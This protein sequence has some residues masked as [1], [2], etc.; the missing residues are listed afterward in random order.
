MLK[1]KSSI[2]ALSAVSLLMAT[3][4][5]FTNQIKSV[6]KQLSASKSNPHKDTLSSD[7]NK[8]SLVK[9]THHMAA[10]ATLKN[11]KGDSIVSNAFNF[12][13]MYKG[14]VD[15]RTG[16]Y[17]FSAQLG[18]VS[19][20]DNFGP[21]YN[22]ALHYSSSDPKNHGYGFGWSDSLSH[23]DNTTQ[24]L[25]LSTGGSYKLQWSGNV[26][27]I[28]YY[29]LD[30]LHLK[31][32]PS[33]KYLF[34]A[35]HKDGTKEY[36]NDFGCVVRLENTRGDSLY[37]H[38][39]QQ[40]SLEN[41]TDDSG[42]IVL[43]TDYVGSSMQVHSLKADGSFNTVS[44]D[45]AN[46]HLQNI[47]L[48]DAK[49]RIAFKYISALGFPGLISSVNY[50]SGAQ[51]TLQYTAIKALTG[52]PEVNIPVVKSDS[53]D[54]GFSQP[55]IR[56]DY[57]YGLTNGHNYLGYASGVQ[58]R[59]DVDNLY[60]R[61]DNYTYQTRVSHYGGPS[62]VETYNK[63]HL[64]LNQKLYQVNSGSLLSEIDYTYPQWLDSTITSLPRNYSLATKVSSIAYDTD[65]NSAE[66]KG[67]YP[68]SIQHSTS[69]QYDD[70][71]NLL[72]K[73]TEDG[74]VT[75]NQYAAADANGF[76]NDLTTQTITPAKLPNAPTLSPV[77]IQMSYKTFPSHDKNMEVGATL[78]TGSVESYQKSAGIW[79]QDMSLAG[80]F[81]EDQSSADYALLTSDKL[82]TFEA[83]SKSEKNANL[84]YTHGKTLTLWGKQY[85]V[86]IK[87]VKLSSPSSSE[88]PSTYTYVSSC[89]GKTLMNIDDRGNKTAYAYDSLGR[90]SKVVLHYGS[91]NQL[92]KSYTYQSSSDENSLTIT[93]PNGY[94]KQEIYDGIGRIIATKQEKIDNNGKG[95]LGQWDLL[96][97][98]TY[99]NQ[100][101]VASETSYDTNELGQRQ[102]QTITNNY[103]DVGRLISKSM[104]NGQSVVMGV[105]VVMRRTYSYDLFPSKDTIATSSLCTLN[106]VA[107]TCKTQHLK[108]SEKD[109]RGDKVTSYMFSLDP[110]ITNN[111][112]QPLY[113]GKLKSE[114][115][116]HLNN[117]IAHGKAFDK[118]WLKTWL[119][120]AIDEKA[121]YT[122]NHSSY[123]AWHKVI[124]TTDTDG[125]TTHYAYDQKGRLISKTLA[126]GSI[127]TYHYDG[128]GDL[129]SVGNATSGK[130]VTLGTREYNAFG[131]MIKSTDVLGN[132]WKYTYDIAGDLTD[133]TTPNGWHIHYKYD[134]LGN[135][136]TRSVINHPE[137]DV[138]F[139]YY[140][141]LNKLRTRQDSTGTTSYTY[142]DNGLVL[143]ME[144][145]TTGAAQGE[146]TPSFNET[147]S[148]TLSGKP[149]QFINASGG[150]TLY[151]Y[152][153]EGQLISADYN[154]KNIANYGYNMEGQLI[155][156][157][158][159]PVVTTNSYNTLGQ[160]SAYNTTVSSGE[161]QEKNISYAFTYAQDGDLIKRVRTS[162]QGNTTENYQYDSINNLLNYACSGALCPK[163]NLGNRIN[164]QKYTFDI[165]N[166]IKTVSTSVTSKAKGIQSNI[167]TYQFDANDPI[168]LLRYTNSNPAY[169]QSATIEY[170]KDGNIITNEHNQKITYTPF[171]QMDSVD[172]QSGIVHYQY[173]G[174]NVQVSELAPGQEPIYFEYGM[175]GLSAIQQNNKVTTLLYAGGRIGEI[176]PD[177][178]Q[179]YTVTDQ[180]GSVLNEAVLSNDGK[181]T[182]TPDHTYTPYGIEGD[183]SSKN[184]NAKTPLVQQNLW[185]FDGQLKDPASGYQF[186]G[187]GYH[188]AYNPVMRRFMS[189]DSA[190]PFGKGGFNG[191]IF[192]RNNPVMYGDP[193]G[194]MPKWLSTVLDIVGEIGS[195][196]TIVVGAATANPGVIAL[197]IAGVTSASLSVASGIEGNQG[198]KGVAEG[199]GIASAVI[200]LPTLVLAGSA[201]SVSAI[202]TV[203]SDVSTMSKVAAVASSSLLMT[204]AATGTAAFG[205]SIFKSG[206][207]AINILTY[208]SLGSGVVGGGLDSISKKTSAG[209][210]SVKVLKGYKAAVP[211]ESDPIF[212]NWVWV[213][214]GKL[215]R[216]SAPYYNENE[217][218]KSQ[219][220]DDDAVEYLKK[221]GV[222]SV[223][224]L[225]HHEL[226]DAE[227]KLL[228]QND[229]EYVFLQVEDMHS[230]SKEQLEKGAAAIANSKGAALVYCGYGQGRTGTQI[231][232][233]QILTGKTGK[234]QAV[235][236][237]TIETKEQEDILFGSIANPRKFH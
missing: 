82:T 23:Y 168:H 235:V 89:N 7:A 178:N 77:K 63:Y 183:T 57:T 130:D 35:I 182:V 42:K 98:K 160:L 163:D 25:S 37:F 188:R 207:P 162:N 175:G 201:S 224:S 54:P 152:D 167:T 93:Y 155:S 104:S 166:N 187:N 47:L 148:Y 198:H 142:A 97:T 76:I 149:A 139:T 100:G 173:N 119:R 192:A 206:S 138:K 8:L 129:V 213:E 131:Q 51:E 133:Y 24:M 103:D 169:D 220:M 29:K 121:Y 214:D 146:G 111:T 13:S 225:N 132:S 48:A 215:A 92:T 102:S 49:T 153:T 3:E 4:Y 158:K 205:T 145:T 43:S 67:K 30:N 200:G 12:S 69:F 99:N 185:G 194:H 143:H 79:S 88:A 14:S 74:T 19:G 114:L 202:N 221:E 181:V 61:P 151:H 193:S 177:G 59:K 116:S 117:D 171:D 33:G 123:N 212:Y 172:T 115:Q 161:S 113:S 208:I 28:Q 128:N 122:V 186:L 136:L 1:L 105:D 189:M 234:Y 156:Y 38:Y 134:D 229:I 11:S 41:I 232:A 236:G 127:Q 86:N 84:T 16:S 227:Q 203:A 217:G 231:A 85:P 176:T 26:P 62:L 191:Y 81:Q 72:Q 209:Y 126:N 56:T 90:M 108:V 34:I 140:P 65:A 204:S 147:Y 39:R 141:L 112:G 73:I 55:I 64:M 137:F 125:H 106:G 144:H 17:S 20:N 180:S 233:W 118:A 68:T 107:H 110:N 21:S 66:L 216:S 196:A 101:K 195:V 45:I 46:G 91:D 22:Y 75:S 58:Y 109:S 6:S 95:I 154:G 27:S 71:G 174:A 124:A 36:F 211:H 135:I 80:S 18:K 5:S 83:G 78:P 52:G 219:F 164:S 96:S 184:S 9:S 226:T 230:P 60:M 31:S 218:D 223:I 87:Q 10:K 190:S 199:L 179:H 15:A 222:T 32:D 70:Q 150:K 170:D 2:I 53:I 159:G 44:V 197:G 165:W 50:T 210:Y 94:Q 40:T 157:N 228:K 237:S 120:E